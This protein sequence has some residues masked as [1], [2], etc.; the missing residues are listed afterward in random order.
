MI[1]TKEEIKKVKVS[2]HK[3]DG[4]G[5]ELDLPR[6]ILDTT[7]TDGWDTYG[8][9]TEYCSLDCLKNAEYLGL[10]GDDDIITLEM[11]MS[12]KDFKI[13]YMVQNG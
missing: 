6:I 9:L 12:V 4:C 5:K 10:G 1:E 3:C 13:M 2:I 7:H 8:M 11:N